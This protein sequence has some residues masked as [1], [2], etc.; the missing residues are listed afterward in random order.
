MIAPQ[1]YARLVR[2]QQVGIGELLE[3]VRDKEA[4]FGGKASPDEI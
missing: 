2:K 3:W 4:K 1:A